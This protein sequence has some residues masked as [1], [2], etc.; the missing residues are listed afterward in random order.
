MF[1]SF[2][3]VAVRSPGRFQLMA[4]RPTIYYF[5]ALFV[6][7]PEPTGDEIFYFPVRKP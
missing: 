6:F 3:L 2:S 5:V 4:M 1:L 7:T